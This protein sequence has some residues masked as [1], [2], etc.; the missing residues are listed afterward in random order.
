MLWLLSLSP[1]L[2]RPCS[3]VAKQALASMPSREDLCAWAYLNCLASGEVRA[4]ICA[5]KQPC[6]CSHL[7]RWLLFSSSTFCQPGPWLQIVHGRQSLPLY[8]LPIMMSAQRHFSYNSALLELSVS[9]QDG[10]PGVRG[11]GA[12]GHMRFR[13]AQGGRG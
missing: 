12:A 8:R 7:D 13:Q 1:L 3:Y 9:H 2:L 5:R 10:Q 4:A 11:R 6:A